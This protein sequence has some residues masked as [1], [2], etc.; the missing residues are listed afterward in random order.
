MDFYCC[1]Y[2]SMVIYEG[3]AAVSQARSLWRVELIRM[4]WH[5][6][7]IGWDQVFR[8]RHI[9]SGRYANQYA[10]IESVHVQPTF[11]HSSLAPS[12]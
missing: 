8:I 11:R 1:E 12:S 10:N 6:A 7:L 4:K 9:T 3:G 2:C 5:G